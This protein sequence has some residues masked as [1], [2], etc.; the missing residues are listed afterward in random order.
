MPRMKD[1]TEGSVEVKV[2]MRDVKTL[3]STARWH[4]ITLVF[5][6]K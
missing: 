6:G 5:S 1:Q 3:D 4:K 2:H